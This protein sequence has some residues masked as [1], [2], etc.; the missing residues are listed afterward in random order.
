MTAPNYNWPNQFQKANTA[1]HSK[2]DK[3]ENILNHSK[4]ALIDIVVNNHNFKYQFYKL[5]FSSFITDLIL[6][7]G[8]Q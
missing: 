2:N 8:V 1:V 7:S 6:L 5:F 3:S 4:L